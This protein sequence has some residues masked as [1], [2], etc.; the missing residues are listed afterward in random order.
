MLCSTV[1]HWID[2]LSPVASSW[3]R[4]DLSDDITCQ[5]D[6]HL[7]QSRPEMSSLILTPCSRERGMEKDGQCQR[8]TRNPGSYEGSLKIYG[9]CSWL[10]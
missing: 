4:N 7:P 5:Q 1:M 6:P 2:V 8:Q 3:S 9:H 10:T